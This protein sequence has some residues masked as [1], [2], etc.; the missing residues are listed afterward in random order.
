MNKKGGNGNQSAEC[1]KFITPVKSY[2]FSHGN[3]PQRNAH[4]WLENMRMMQQTLISQD[5]G[6]RGGSGTCITP[7]LQHTGPQSPYNHTEMGKQLNYS[8]MREMQDSIHDHHAFKGGHRIKKTR[9]QKQE[10]QKQEEQKQKQEEQK[11]KQEE[12]KQKQEEQKQKQEEQKQ[13]EQKQEDK[14]KFNIFN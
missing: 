1:R 8:K 7:T 12:Q 3:T 13:E 6:H 11:Q 14:Y 5:N 4:G 2:S 10:E 9:K